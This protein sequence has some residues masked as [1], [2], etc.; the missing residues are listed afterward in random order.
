NDEQIGV[1]LGIFPD[2]QQYEFRIGKDGPVIYGSV[3]EDLD[4]HY[5]ANPSSILLKPVRARFLVLTK[6]RA[7]QMQRTEKILETLTPIESL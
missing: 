5:L 6:F 3:S 4:K 7:G 2:R 1:L